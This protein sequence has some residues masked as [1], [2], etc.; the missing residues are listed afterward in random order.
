VK[1]VPR[2]I[3]PG[4]EGPGTARRR[5]GSHPP[6]SD[7]RRRAARAAVSVARVPEFVEVADRVWVAR[8]EWVDVNITAIGG[9]RGLVVVD[10]HGSTAAGRRVVADLRRLGAGRVAHVV[11]S[12]WHWDHT[13]G[14]AAFRAS[15]PDAPIHA[16]E[17]AARWLAEHGE[18]RRRRFAESTDDP[19]A[20]EV[21]ATEIVAPDTTFART[22][23][24]D[25]GDREIELAFIG[26][27]HTSGDIVVRVADAN[28]LVAGDLV[29]E[30]AHPWIGLDAW[31]LEW[32]TT[33]DAL[34][35]G[36]DHRTSVVPGHGVVVDPAFVRAQRRELAEIAATVRTLAGLGVPADRAA[37][38]GVWPWEVDERIRNAVTRGYDALSPPGAGPS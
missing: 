18:Q 21:G 37:V 23:R 13:F 20:A 3:R 4:V 36:T 9:A 34:L 33:L 14:N 2:A 38:E 27:G 28:L 8:Y 25:L 19:H 12:H 22:H 35:V 11:N 26:R 29:E 17:E 6:R 16:H 5:T 7:R 31:P 10:T 32:P 30:S 15:A 1:A 24:L